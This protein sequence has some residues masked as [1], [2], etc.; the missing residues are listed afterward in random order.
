MEMTIV[1]IA[2]NSNDDDDGHHRCVTNYTYSIPPCNSVQ[3]LKEA[4]AAVGC[5]LDA[6]DEVEQLFEGFGW[7]PLTNSL[8][9]SQGNQVHLRAQQGTPPHLNHLLHHICEK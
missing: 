2:L 4:L 7:F 1:N 3:V 9:I 6:F 8:I 5:D